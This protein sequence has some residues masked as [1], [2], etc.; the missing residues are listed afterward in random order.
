MS[1]EMCDARRPTSGIGDSNY[2]LLA[3]VEFCD[4]IESPDHFECPICFTEFQ[5]GEGVMLR[6]CL[7]TFCTYVLSLL[8]G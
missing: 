3:A 7:H 2:D 4:V 8:I 6:E 1:C 5:P